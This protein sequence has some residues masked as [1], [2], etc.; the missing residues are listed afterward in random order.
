[1]GTRAGT[2]V[3]QTAE[4]QIGEE[5]YMEMNRKG[6]HV[7]IV[8][9]KVDILEYL[10]HE[11]IW[12]LVQNE[13]DTDEYLEEIDIKALSNELRLSVILDV[14]PEDEPTNKEVYRRENGV[15]VV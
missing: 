15:P 14:H 11:R 2:A 3:L 8:L 13:I 7:E 6:K 12:D 5:E 1:V 4:L 9:N 10:R